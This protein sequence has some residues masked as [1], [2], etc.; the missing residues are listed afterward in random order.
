MNDLFFLAWNHFCFDF[1]IYCGHNNL[2]KDLEYNTVFEQAKDQTTMTEVLDCIG[3]DS[4]RLKYIRSGFAS[5]YR[6][7]W[8]D[9]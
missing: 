4:T 9:V 6:H 8:Y 5:R 2:Y 3:D 7:M 1:S